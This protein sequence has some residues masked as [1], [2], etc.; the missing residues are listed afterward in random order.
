MFHL[1]FGV[2]IWRVELSKNER[3]PIFVETSGARPTFV[4]A[5]IESEISVIL[6]YVA[7][8]W[9]LICFLF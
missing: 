4:M 1:Q 7:V 8:V 6:S 5:K 2:F 9:T 3:K